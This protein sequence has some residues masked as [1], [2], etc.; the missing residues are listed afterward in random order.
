M[1]ID[2]NN[3]PKHIAIIMDGNGRWAESQGNQRTVGHKYGVDSIRQV[4]KTATQIG[5]QYLTIYAFSQENWGRP[6]QEVD[7]L[8]EL[9]AN[10]IIS[11][12]DQLTTN[13]V[14]L[15]FIG[16]LEKLP[17]KLQESIHIAQQI[18]PTITK[19]NLVIALN[20]SSQ[21]E[22]TQAT[23]KIAQLVRENQLDPTQITPQTIQDNLYTHNIPNP[24]LLIRTSAEQ[25]LSNF[26]L[27]QLSYTELYF[28]PTLWPDFDHQQLIIAIQHYQ[29][30]NRRFG[31]I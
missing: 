19:L 23:Q 7:F 29:Q 26:M 25:R 12:L 2:P 11:E 24:E 10:T 13:N 6:K 18:T 17:P 20:Y 16:D 21:Y 1:E 27:W 8:M 4:V 3:I 30:R 31:K 14:K 5:V 22:I 15:Q 9:I 28:T